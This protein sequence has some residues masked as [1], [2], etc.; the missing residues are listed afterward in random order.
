M[1]FGT[2]R[3]YHVYVIFSYLNFVRNMHSGRIVQTDL[4]ESLP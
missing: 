1:Y 2:E 4:W 3:R